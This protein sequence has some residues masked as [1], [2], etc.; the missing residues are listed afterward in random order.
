[1]R[2]LW[3]V[4]LLGATVASAGEPVVSDAVARSVLHTG[5]VFVYDSVKNKVQSVVRVEVGP[6]DEDLC[7][8]YVSE[9]VDL[10]ALKSASAVSK[11]RTRASLLDRVTLTESLPTETVHVTVPL[12]GFMVRRYSHISHAGRWLE[13]WDFAMENPSIP[14]RYQREIDGVERLRFEA[15]R[16]VYDMSGVSV[17]SMTP[18]P[19]VGAQKPRANR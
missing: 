13:R 11:R 16:V 1:M 14:I 15:R 4:G 8:L 6:C 12:G 9:A 10:Q 2:A 19:P 5:N 7:E 3:I 18:G 17:D